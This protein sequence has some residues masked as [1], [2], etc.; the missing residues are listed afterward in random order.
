MD[1]MLLQLKAWERFLTQENRE[2]AAQFRL[3]VQNAY[4]VLANSGSKAG[5]QDLLDFYQTPNYDI[6][7]RPSLTTWA[8]ISID[9]NTSIINQTDH[10][11]ADIL[12][13][14]GRACRTYRFEGF[15]QL[16]LY[17]AYTNTQQHHFEQSTLTI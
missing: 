11:F 9:A 7:E 5:L 17:E 10:Y 2:T 6:K 16:T 14:Y 8:T 13:K 12:N 15:K 1:E 4:D 3:R